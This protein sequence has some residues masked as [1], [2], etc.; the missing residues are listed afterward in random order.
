MLAALCLSVEM[1]HFGSGISLTAWIVFA[2]SFAV[3][4]DRRRGAPNP[5]RRQGVTGLA[6]LAPAA[7]IALAVFSSGA[8][9]FAAFLGPWLVLYHVWVFGDIPWAYSL[10]IQVGTGAY[11][12]GAAA[13]SWAACT[14][15]RRFFP[16]G[17]D[18]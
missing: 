15:A 17:K 14:T 9:L 11:I 8:A 6:A 13:A 16:L 12:L 5:F 18:A 3:L 7:G 1:Y 10:F 2:P 4:L